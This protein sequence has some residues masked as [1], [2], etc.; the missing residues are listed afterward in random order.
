M[1][2]SI[3]N[4]AESDAQRQYEKNILKLDGVKSYT[5]FTD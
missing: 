4:A 3:K 2:E 5:M 1:Y